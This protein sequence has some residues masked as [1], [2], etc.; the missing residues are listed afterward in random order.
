MGG[1][2]SYDFPL[3]SQCP[4]PV[5]LP[6]PVVQA[7]FGFLLGLGS[8]KLPRWPMPA[9]FLF[10]LSCSVVLDTYARLDGWA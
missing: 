2:L 7:L 9:A 1:D 8:D 4:E 6:L 10:C 5:C 3:T